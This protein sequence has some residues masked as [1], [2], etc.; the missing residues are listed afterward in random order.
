[1]V[2]CSFKKFLEQSP[3]SNQYSVAQRIFFR[4]LTVFKKNYIKLKNEKKTIGS[5]LTFRKNWFCIR[6]PNFAFWKHFTNIQSLRRFNLSI[7]Q[8]SKQIYGKLQYRKTLFG[9]FQCLPHFPRKMLLCSW[10]QLCIFE[11]GTNI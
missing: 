6:W 5:C 10:T 1:M 9:K 8:I 4:L 11:P 7:W 2:L 3:V